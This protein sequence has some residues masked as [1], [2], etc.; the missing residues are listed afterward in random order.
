MRVDVANGG[1]HH[2]GWNTKDFR[3]SH[4]A[5]IGMDADAGYRLDA[6][7][8]RIDP[9]TVTNDKGFQSG[10]HYHALAPTG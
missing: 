4:N 6:T 7:F 1:L 8:V 2:T 9:W 3:K 10:N 5:V